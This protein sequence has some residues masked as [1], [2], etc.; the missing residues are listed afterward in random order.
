MDTLVPPEPPST[1]DGFGP[2][3]LGVRIPAVRVPIIA[4]TF[5]LAA[6][7]GTVEAIQ[8][9]R[10]G[11]PRFGRRELLVRLVEVDGRWEETVLQEPPP[12]PP[13][14]PARLVIRREGV[15]GVVDSI[16]WWLGHRS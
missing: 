1:E 9:W 6:P 2:N 16:R 5:Y 11:S 15:A 7:R 13:Q 8:E 12:P 4:A 10:A 3:S 14:P